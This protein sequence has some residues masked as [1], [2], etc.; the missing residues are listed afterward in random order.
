MDAGDYFQDND[1]FPDM[2]DLF[3]DD[4][5]IPFPSNMFRLVVA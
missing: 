1:F 4:A 5:S 2:N 3:T